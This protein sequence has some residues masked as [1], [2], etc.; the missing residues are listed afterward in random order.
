MVQ[1]AICDDIPLYMNIILGL[2]EIYQEERPGI[3]LN[4][5]CFNSADQLLEKIKIIET[6]VDLYD[7]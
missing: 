4:M 7:R 5:H 1:V 6:K 3:K 2:L